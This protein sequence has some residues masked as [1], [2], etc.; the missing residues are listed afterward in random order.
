[1]TGPPDGPFQLYLWFMLL[2]ELPLTQSAPPCLC[3]G[4]QMVPYIE[5]FLAGILLP[6]PGRLL[7]QNIKWLQAIS[8][9]DSSQIHY[10]FPSLNFWQ[11]EL[12]SGCSRD[13]SHSCQTTSPTLFICTS[14]SRAEVRL[15]PL[16]AQTQRRNNKLSEQSLQLPLTLFR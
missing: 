2:F 3:P 5:I 10:G 15:S 14:I 8:T 11:E 13:S 1:M 4:S 12:L 7:C 9:S 16:W 6:L